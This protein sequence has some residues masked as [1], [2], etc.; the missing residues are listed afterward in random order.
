MLHF[1]FLMKASHEILLFLYSLEYTF[2][3]PTFDNIQTLRLLVML[4]KYVSDYPS[5]VKAWRVASGPA[6]STQGTRRSDDTWDMMTHDDPAHDDIWW[7]MWS[8]MMTHDDTWDMMTHVITHYDTWC[9][10]ITY[11]RTLWLKLNVMTND[12]TPLCFSVYP[13]AIT[14]Q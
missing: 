9:H 1:F 11:D 2:S 6:Q 7:H 10:I 12:D 8:H 14:M 13:I 3:V 4:H 5:G